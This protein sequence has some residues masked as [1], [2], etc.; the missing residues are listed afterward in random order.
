L[1]EK[2]IVTFRVDKRDW[3]VFKKIAKIKESDANK[4]LRKFIKQYIQ[5]NKEYIER[6]F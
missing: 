5:D 4:E 1:E 6:L 3:E 2:K